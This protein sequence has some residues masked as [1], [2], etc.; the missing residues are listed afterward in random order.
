VAPEGGYPV[1]QPQVHPVQVS[2]AHQEH[3]SRGL[4]CLGIPFFF[5]RAIALVP[6]MIWLYVLMLAAEVVALLMQFVVLFTG[7]YPTGPHRFVTG[8]VRLS[9]KQAAWLLG[10]TDRYPGFR[11]D[12]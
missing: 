10:L 7:R 2:I 5:G 3:Y 1:Q 6:V 12:P 11:L 8:V 9:T 4:G